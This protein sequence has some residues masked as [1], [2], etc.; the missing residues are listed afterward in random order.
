LEIL[1]EI[2]EG[3]LKFVVNKDK[4]H[5]ISVYEGVPYLGFVI[6]PKV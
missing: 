4:T 5:I 1:C 3:E 2:L 6:Y